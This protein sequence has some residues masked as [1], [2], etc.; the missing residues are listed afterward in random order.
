MDVT[1][2]IRPQKIVTSTSILCVF[3]LD[4]SLSHYEETSTCCEILYGGAHVAGHQR[5]PPASGSWGTEDP[6][7][8]ANK[9]LNLANSCMSELESQLAAELLT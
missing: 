3:Y 5:G 4:F 1:S 6:S 9:E 7:T 2:K 8:R